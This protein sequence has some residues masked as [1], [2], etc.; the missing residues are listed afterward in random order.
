MTEEVVIEEE[1]SWHSYPKVY[2]MGHAA[3]AELLFDEI[4]VEEKIDGSQFSFGRFGGELKVRSKRVA[5][6][7]EAPEKMFSK[8]VEV[9][10]ALPLTDG[11]T[12]RAEYL[13]KPKHNALA[14]DRIPDSHLMVF[15]INTGHEH[16]MSYEEKAKE[17]ERVGLEC[18]PRL[19][20]GK[21]TSS[22]Q[23]LSY[24]ESPSC[25]GGVKPEGVV[26][27][28]YKRFSRDGK[29][30]I[31]KYVSEAFKEV[32][33][34][35]WSK[36]NPSQGDFIKDL[37]EKYRH[38]GRWMKAVQRLEEEGALEHSPRDIGKLMKEVPVDIRDECRDEIMEALYKH[39]WP[40][41]H[42]VTV[43]GLPQWYKERL[44]ER[45]FEGGE[46]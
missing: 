41:I 9:A 12:Y 28:N 16:Y 27:K 3:I 33:K 29:A 11:Y 8:A 46:S 6:E 14:Y 37:A 43:R 5:M 36:S 18:V 10:K 38:V 42:R 15:D 4:H 34:S 20:K 22:A 26:V 19:Y 32:H 1:T 21:L 40:Q 44:L 2:A 13:Q 23:L 7:V 25:L 17:C 31:G 39:F 30:M 45:Q 35:S 24:L